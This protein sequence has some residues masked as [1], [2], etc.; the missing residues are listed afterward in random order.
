MCLGFLSFFIMLLVDL[1]IKDNN[2][3]VGICICLLFCV[4]LLD[5]WG[6]LLFDFFLGIDL[7]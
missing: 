7:Y 5:I 2:F 6:L 1:F 4:F 3:E